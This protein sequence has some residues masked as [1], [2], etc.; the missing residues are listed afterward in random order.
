MAYAN[1]QTLPIQPVPTPILCSPYTEPTAHWLYDRETGTP[2]R[3]PGR[4]AAKYWYKIK[5]S[6]R[7]QGSLELLEG[8]ED[9]VA[10]NQIRNDVRRWRAGGYEGVTPITRELLRFWNKPDRERRLF[11]TPQSPARADLWLPSI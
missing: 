10:V 4:R 7:G 11:F 5:E 1:R 6:A 3:Q 9:L 8:Q 2:A